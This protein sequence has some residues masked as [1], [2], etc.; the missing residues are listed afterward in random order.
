LLARN[1]LIA[2]LLALNV[3]ENRLSQ[4]HDLI[5]EFGPE[6]LKAKLIQILKRIFVSQR[7]H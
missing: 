7:T 2:D 1:D 3:V 4:I 5:E 6:L